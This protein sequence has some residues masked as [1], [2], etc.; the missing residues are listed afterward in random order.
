MRAFLMVLSILL[1]QS[2][3]ASLVNV[4][5]DTCQQRGVLD[6]VKVAQCKQVKN[7]K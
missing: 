3:A 7:V 2:C 1:L 6:G 5:F 4:D